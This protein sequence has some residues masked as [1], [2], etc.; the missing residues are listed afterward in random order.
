MTKTKTTTII[1]SV[2]RCMPMEIRKG[3]FKAFFLFFYHISLKHRLI[4]LHNLRCAFPEKE[5]DEL[6]SIAKGV[7]RHLAIV[8]AEFFEL[9][10]ITKENFDEWV[11]VEGSE[12][13]HAAIAQKKGMLSIISHFG[14]WELMAIAVPI[15]FKP[16]HVVYRPLDSPV[17]ENLFSWVRTLHGNGL[18]AKG[19]SGKIIESRLAENNGVGVLID[20]NVAAREGVFVDFFGRPACTG[21][22]L[23]VLALR[24][25]APVIPAFMTRMRNG[26]YKF[27]VKPAIEIVCSGNYESDLQVNTQRFTKIIEDMIRQYPDQWFWMHQ[28][29]KTKLCQAKTESRTG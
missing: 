6:I 23:A 24:T 2:F 15:L 16:M 26:K 12:Y 29:W 18:I 25:S 13:V 10:F 28:R 14:N 27:I 9:P 20:Q 3:I 22:G 17:M 19:G 21:V 11:V 7:Y 1:F 5:W 4:T 8:M